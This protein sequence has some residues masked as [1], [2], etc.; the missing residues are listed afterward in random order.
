MGAVDLIADWTDGDAIG[1][2]IALIIRG[3]ACDLAKIRNNAVD[4][5]IPLAYGRHFE[6]QAPNVKIT[7][8]KK[9]V[10]RRAGVQ[11]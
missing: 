4:A 11:A 8:R 10:D 9:W 7:A 6:G 2:H 5:A 3:I 1:K